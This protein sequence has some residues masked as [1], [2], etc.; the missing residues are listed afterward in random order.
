[1]QTKETFGKDF[2]YISPYDDDED[3]EYDSDEGSDFD[4]Y[5][6]SYGFR[7]ETDHGEDHGEFPSVRENT[8]VDLT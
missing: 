8:I 3:Y 6:D 1:M 2:V 5:Y 4:D 7:Y